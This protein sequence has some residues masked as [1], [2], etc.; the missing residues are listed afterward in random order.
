MSIVSG[1]RWG[2]DMPSV[3][4]SFKAITRAP[5]RLVCS[6]SPR[7]LQARLT[8]ALDDEAHP[9]TRRRE[10]RG[11]AAAGH[12]DHAPLEGAVAAGEEI[13]QPCPGIARMAHPIA[14]LC[15]AALVLG[16]STDRD[17]SPWVP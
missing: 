5:W 1:E 6:A 17:R 13:R 8:E 12:H 10:L 9:V 14:G 3:I 2:S 11:D 16:V 15:L 4:R 7:N